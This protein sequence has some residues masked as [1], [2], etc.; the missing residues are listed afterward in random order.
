MKYWLGLL[1]FVTPGFVGEVRQDEPSEP[2]PNIVLILAD[3]LGYGDLSSYGSD[4]FRTPHLDQLAKEGMRFTDAYANSP[5]CAPTRA[6][7]LSGQYAPRTGVYTVNSPARGPVAER[8]LV[9]AENRR[10]LEP[11]VETLAEAI[12]SAGY[13]TA[14][15]GK[16]HLG[17][18]AET[19]PLG[20]GFDVNLGGNQRGHP[21]SYFSPYSNSEL[22]DG[23]DGEYLT[24]RL[25]NE[26]IGFIESNREQPFFLYLPYYSVHTPIQPNGEDLERMQDREPGT[27]HTNAR[28]GA[29]VEGM[30]A[31][32]GRILAA[33]DRLKLAEN[34]IVVFASDNGGKSPE[35]DMLP[36]RGSKGMLYEGGIRVP[37]IVRWPG[38][39]KASSESHEPVLTFDLYPTL[40]AAIGGELPKDTPIDGR[41]LAP[42]LADSSANLGREAIFWHFPA[43][44]HG[45]KSMAEEGPR[46]GWR[47]TPSS[48]MRCGKWKLIQSFETNS[49]ELYNLTEDPGEQTNLASIR[50]EVFKGLKSQLEAWQQSTDAPVDFPLNP[51]YEG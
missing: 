43:Y 11:N 3:D 19:G 14:H 2:G 13:K 22:T 36:L 12:R 26:A 9:P 40:V 45:Y 51:N 44:L 32:V 49:F 41:D 31:Q 10:S 5:N 4:F 25:T 34:T 29:M 18:G 7:L 39:T 42:V 27:V 50:T 48:A 16:W 47:A 17:E 35:T 15:I 1:L 20:Q 21:A 8:L 23:P 33:L 38:V 46:P 37:M 6:A 28:Y 24:E 30:D